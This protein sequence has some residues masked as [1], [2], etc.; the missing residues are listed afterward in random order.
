MFENDRFSGEKCAWTG[1]KV[2]ESWRYRKQYMLK[3]SLLSLSEASIQPRMGR[4]KFGNWFAEIQCTGV[5]VMCNAATI[6]YNYIQSH[7]M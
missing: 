3:M 2:C 4:L 5:S 6:T 1:A 7:S